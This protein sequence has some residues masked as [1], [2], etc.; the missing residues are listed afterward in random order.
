MS[1]KDKKE[2][3]A[4]LRDFLVAIPG[5]FDR[6]VASLSWLVV[7]GA[8]A[9][10]ALLLHLMVGGAGHRR[11]A[12][13]PGGHGDNPSGALYVRDLGRLP[14]GRHTFDLVY[15]LVLRN[16]T[17]GPFAV[18][19][20]LDRLAIG[21]LV[22]GGDVVELGQAPGLFDESSARV[23]GAIAWHVAAISPKGGRNDRHN[24]PLVGDYQPGRW[25][26]HAAHYRINARLD[27]FADVAIGYGLR[28]RPHGWFGRPG[29]IDNDAHDEEVQLGAVLRSHCPLGVKIQHGEVRSLCGA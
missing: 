21:D 8:V 23:P 24:G 7:L 25:R 1:R 16:E 3:R 13:P 17:G 14:D 10:G 20:S 26:S 5:A 19:S 6:A 9:L 27:Q 11:P 18:E 2:R 15:E 29:D 22:T 28:H 4:A 12:P